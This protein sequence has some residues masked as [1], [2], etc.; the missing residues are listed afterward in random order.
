MVEVKSGILSDRMRPVL[1]VRIISEIK[2]N[3]AWPSRGWRLWRQH[4]RN[5]SLTR[6]KEQAPR[7]TGKSNVPRRGARVPSFTSELLTTPESLLLLMTT[8]KTRLH[9]YTPRALCLSPFAYKHSKCNSL[10]NST[11][12]SSSARIGNALNAEANLQHD[13][14]IHVLTSSTKTSHLM[15]GLFGTDFD[16]YTLDRRDAL[17]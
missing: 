9:L 8:R 5:R 2:L 11:F 7:S 10:K 3:A 6:A 13:A 14:I 17:F 16:S 4:R 12:N 1:Y 15:S